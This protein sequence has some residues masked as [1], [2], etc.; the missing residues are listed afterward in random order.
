MK[1]DVVKD[2]KIQSFIKKKYI[3]IIQSK[4][5]TVRLN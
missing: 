4:L 3:Y 2:N 1:E 5:K